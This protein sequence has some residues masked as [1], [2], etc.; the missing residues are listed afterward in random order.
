MNRVLAAL[1]S[2]RVE[3]RSLGDFGRAGNYFSR[4]IT[5]WTHQYKA[6]ETGSI[7]EMDSLMAWLPRN[8]PPDEG[9]SSLVHGDYRLDNMIFDRAEPRVRAVL[10]WELSTLGHPLAD[11]SYQ[12]MAWHIPYGLFRGIQGLD[13]KSLGIPEERDYVDAYCERTSRA[14]IAHWDFYLAYNFFRIAAILQG[15]KKR[16]LDGVGSSALPAHELNSISALAHIGWT[17]ARRTGG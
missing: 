12:C 8:T 4:Q 1:H 5:R 11:L 10:D 7:P 13:L 16:M 6:S 9:D 2:V 17:F 15:V 3:D 14:G